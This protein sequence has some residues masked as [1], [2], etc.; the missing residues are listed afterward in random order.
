MYE[1]SVYS[2]IPGLYE[3]WGPYLTL[4]GVSTFLLPNTQKNKKKEGRVYSGAWFQFTVSLLHDCDK[5]KY[6]CG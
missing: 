1:V 6:F 3:G 4:V 2:V 5:I